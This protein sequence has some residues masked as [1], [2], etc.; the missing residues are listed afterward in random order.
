MV[1][2]GIRGRALALA[3]VVLALAPGL[4]RAEVAIIM[5][6]SPT[7][8]AMTDT[9][10]I[11]IQLDIAGV[12]GPERFFE[13]SF[14]HFEIVDRHVQPPT[15]SMSFDPRRGQEIRTHQ[16]RRYVLR[17]TRPGRLRIEPAA[18][19]VRGERYETRGAVIEVGSA[20]ADLGAPDDP[21]AAFAG[22]AR[23]PGF[24]P[25]DPG[26]DEEVFLH[27][28]VDRRELHVGEQAIVTW[29][30]YARSDV[31][32]FEPQ[33]PSL[34]LVWS[35]I[36]HEPDTYF[37]YHEAR[38]GGRAYTVAI[39]SKRA[40]FPTRP[41]ALEIEPFRARVTTL[42]SPLDEPMFVESDRLVLAVKGLPEGAPPDFDPS[43]VGRYEVEAS[44]DRA[45]I[46]AGEFFTLALTVRGEGA[47]RRTSP[48]RLDLEGFDVRVPR[49]F[50]QTIE[51]ADDVVR[52]ERVY[53]YWVTPLRGG[54]QVIPA[55]EL[56]YFDPATETFERT[57]TD[58]I[59]VEV[60]GDPSLVTATDGDG[61]AVMRR[62]IRLIREGTQIAS[63]TTPGLY[64]L[65]WYWLIV[66]ALPLLY[67]ALVIGD[68]VRRRLRRET[69]RSR[70]RRARGRAQRRFRVAEIHLRGQRPAQFFGELT[71]VI[72][73][74]IEERVGRP[75]H[76]LTRAELKRYLHERGVPRQTVEA[77]DRELESFDVA[78]FS[79]SASGPG[80]M[81]QALKRTRDL[82]REIEKAPLTELDAM[83]REAAS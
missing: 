42:E 14:E 11:T 60:R 54:E 56:S 4:A 63:R 26:R 55:I 61:E 67:L 49:D 81:R 72:H 8:G 76:S 80:E 31:L 18:V 74:H 73:E 62:D 13:P 38:I 47:I 33:V 82:L 69:P 25:P 58:P 22:I 10:V 65:W 24:Q 48:P 68:R 51:A 34:D 20:R 19:Q 45:T 5:D 23:V 43:Y 52:G 78:R 46:D 2:T 27:A 64:R 83:G 17:P 36:L 29:L 77:L 59:P 21:G 66:V 40:L 3:L 57:R 28:V 50:E 37:T 9:Y 41:G 15:T 16:T 79:P 30:L 75:V 70:L 12:S 7:A 71:R 1:R 32:R 39:V 6:V 53:G 35:E 44:V